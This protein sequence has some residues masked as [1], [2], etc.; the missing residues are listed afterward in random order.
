MRKNVYHTKIVYIAIEETV[1]GYIRILP[2]DC[3]DVF[4]RAMALA[5]EALEW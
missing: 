1:A 2:A 3:L 5:S 4:K